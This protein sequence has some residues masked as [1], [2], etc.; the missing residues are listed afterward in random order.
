[1]TNK[2]ENKQLEDKKSLMELEMLKLKKQNDE[3][4][5]VNLTSIKQEIENDK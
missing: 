3:E 4:D 2:K 1:M 5:H